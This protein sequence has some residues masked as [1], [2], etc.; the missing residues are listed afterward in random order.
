MK[1]PGARGGAGRCL[2]ITGLAVKCCCCCCIKEK[3]GFLLRGLFSFGPYG[4]GLTRAED[5]GTLSHGAKSRPARIGVDTTGTAR[6]LRV[7]CPACSENFGVQ[8]SPA[9]RSVTDRY[10]SS[11]HHRPLH[12]YAHQATNPYLPPH[13]Q[14]SPARLELTIS[15]NEFTIST[16]EL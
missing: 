16:E 8:S 15:A 2:S 5:E 1:R 6:Q 9:L 12:T 14:P 7:V 3:A 10:T 11:A 4:G 13:P